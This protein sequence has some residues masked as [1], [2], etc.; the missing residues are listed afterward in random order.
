MYSPAMKHRILALS[1][2]CTLI[3]A[4]AAVLGTDLLPGTAFGKTVPPIPALAAS[5]G[6]DSD[7]S[8][9]PESGTFAPTIKKASPRCCEHH[10]VDD[11][12]Q[13]GGPR[14]F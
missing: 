5:V 4:L 10:R 1:G 6:P 2:A 9:I 12:A 7:A 8:R 14:A 13:P 11:G 3:L